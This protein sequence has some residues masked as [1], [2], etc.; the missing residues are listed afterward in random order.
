MNCGTEKS[1]DCVAPYG[2][3]TDYAMVVI[4]RNPGKADH[5]HA[6]ESGI[7]EATFR[8]ARDRIKAQENITSAENSAPPKKLN[9]ISVFRQ[10]LNPVSQNTAPNNGIDISGHIN[11]KNFSDE[12]STAAALANSAR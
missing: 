2:R 12:N 3:R 8:R 7:N 6:R 5:A 4:K 9:G 10:Q 11:T 1:C